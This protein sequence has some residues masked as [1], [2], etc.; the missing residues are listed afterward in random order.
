MTNYDPA[1]T[2]PEEAHPVQSRPRTTYEAKSAILSEIDYALNSPLL[3]RFLS[4]DA[5]NLLY[6]QRVFWTQ[7]TD[8][9]LQ[10]ILDGLP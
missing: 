2:Y 9:E 6:A 3:S 4:Q 5:R 10:K 8:A 7:A 1:K